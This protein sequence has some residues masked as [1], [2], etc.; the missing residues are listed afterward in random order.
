MHQTVNDIVKTFPNILNYLT[1]IGGHTLDF[2][3]FYHFFE[4]FIL[5]NL[6]P[7]KSSLSPL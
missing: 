2:K 3:K 5:F 6:L 1:L 7:N 4:N